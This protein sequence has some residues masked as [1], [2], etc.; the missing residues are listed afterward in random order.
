[1]AW[2]PESRYAG[3]HQLGD[4]ESPVL[5]G[6]RPPFIQGARPGPKSEVEIGAAR[7]A[8]LSSASKIASAGVGAHSRAAFYARR[9]A[10]GSFARIKAPK[11]IGLRPHGGDARLAGTS[12][13]MAA[14]TL[15]CT[16]PIIRRR[17]AVTPST[18]SAIRR[19]EA[20]AAVGPRI[21][22]HLR[23]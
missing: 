3:R 16:R 9:P 2:P 21:W 14:T 10:S 18:S 6:G 1:M 22:A 4:A 17:V 23:R 15:I 19:P 7:W 5:S 8:H 13:A 11:E 12:R 20:S